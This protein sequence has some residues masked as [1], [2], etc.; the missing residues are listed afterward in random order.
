M[1]FKAIHLAK[2]KEEAMQLL[3]AVIED[4]AIPYNRRIQRL[5]T[6]RG[7]E[8]IGHDS[9]LCCKDFGIRHYIFLHICLH[10]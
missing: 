10:R 5:R 3:G 9:E 1:V 6:D 7:G 4:L 8:S 2:S